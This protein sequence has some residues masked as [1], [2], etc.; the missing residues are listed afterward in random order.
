MASRQPVRPWFAWYVVG[1]LTLALVSSFVDRQ[2]L[3]LMVGPIKRDLGVSDSGMSLLGGLSFALFYTFLG[4]PIAQP[5][6]FT[7]LAGVFSIALAALLWEAPARVLLERLIGRAV[8]AAN[9]LS[10]L[11]TLLWLVSGK[12]DVDVTGKVVL[13]IVTAI[14]AVFALLEARYFQ[15]AA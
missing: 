11:V 9:G 3:S 10:V 1:V 2:I 8:C 7:Q 4:L 5:E 6:L 15:P 13:G 12:L 14:L